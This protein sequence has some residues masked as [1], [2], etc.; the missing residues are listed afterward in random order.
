MPVKFS[1]FTKMCTKRNLNKDY[2][3]IPYESSVQNMPSPVRVQI[4]KNLASLKHLSKLKKQPTK[5]MTRPDFQSTQIN[6]SPV[7]RTEK[8]KITSTIIQQD[9]INSSD[10]SSGP[11]LT[12]ISS[13]SSAFTNSSYYS[14]ELTNRRRSSIFTS[15]TSSEFHETQY[16][17]SSSYN[18]ENFQEINPSFFDKENNKSSTSV[19]NSSDSTVYVCIESYNSKFQGDIQLQYT[20]RV[21]VIHATE[22]YSLVKHISTKEVGYVPTS[23]LTSFSQFIKRF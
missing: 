19:T 13:E 4:N 18:S 21:H 17:D 16:L 1:L 20:D 6:E 9:T 5:I 22:D 14:P 23:C 8:S 3:C 11:S 2:E 7:K 12:Y 15:D 10:E